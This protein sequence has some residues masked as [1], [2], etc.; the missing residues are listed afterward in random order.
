MAQ[1][2]A[3]KNILIACAVVGAAMI[4]YMGYVAGHGNT[5]SAPVKTEMSQ[6]RQG[7]I[8]AHCAGTMA[9]Q[10]KMTGD[11]GRSDSAQYR[12]LAIRFSVKAESLM[13]REQGRAVTTEVFEQ[14]D[15]AMDVAAE[16]GPN[17]QEYQE[18]SRSFRAETQSCFNLARTAGLLSPSV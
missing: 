3:Q 4:G 10:A 17:T 2:T 8:Y 5:Q 13:G 14:T 18:F 12:D 15:R 6:E 7:R 16:T 11:L 1:T 9:Y